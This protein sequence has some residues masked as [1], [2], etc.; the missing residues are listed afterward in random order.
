MLRKMLIVVPLS[1]GHTHLLLDSRL[2]DRVEQT[3]AG[4]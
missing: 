4:V 2:F 3:A 1:K